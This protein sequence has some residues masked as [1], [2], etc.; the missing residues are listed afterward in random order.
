MVYVQTRIRSKKERRIKFSDT[1]IESDHQILTR[2]RYQVLIRK[3]KNLSIKW[4]LLNHWM[5]EYR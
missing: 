5:I 3:K 4:I 1:E 2:R